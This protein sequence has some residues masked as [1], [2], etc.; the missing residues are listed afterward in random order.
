MDADR[1]GR[2]R[3][4]KHGAALAGFAVGGIRSAKGETTWSERPEVHPVDVGAYGHRSHFVTSE[5]TDDYPKQGFQGM[6]GARKN[7]PL[8]DVI[9]IITPSSLHFVRSHTT[10]PDVDPKEYR[11]SIFGLVQRPL[12]FSLEDLKRL[13]SESRVHFLECQG[14]S[15]PGDHGGK[16][17]AFSTV[18]DLHGGTSCSEW[19]GVPLSVLFKE[20]GLK[21]GAIW[22]VSDG[23]DAGEFSYTLPL[24]KALDDAMVA[25][26][27][28]GEPLRPEQGYPVRLLVPGWEAPYSVKWLRQ[29]KVVDKPYMAWDEAIE[30]SVPRA[31]LG[32]KSRWFHFQMPPKSLI[33]RPSGGQQLPGRGFYE[34]TGLAWSGGGAVRRV[35]VSTDGGRS[36][37]DA[38]LQEPVHRK[39]HTRFTLDWSW[40]GAETV[41]QSRCTDENGEVQPSLAQLSKAWGISG[42]HTW[43]TAGHAFHFNAI[44]PW[45]IAT[46]GS[47]QDAMFS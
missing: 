16:K 5:R 3:F 6:F 18:Q 30:H 31:D 28:N 43:Q 36:W 33:I 19:T 22:L 41:L 1:S 15:S 11:L 26:G 39:A 37:K 42:K 29:I 20:T 38:K 34:I 35:E 40:D 45:R 47:V 23:S 8:Q 46:D 21:K 14:N 24:E 32:G 13:P 2:R 9:G 44:Q 7:A 12:D 25:Y 17:M 27:Q 10:P 4:L